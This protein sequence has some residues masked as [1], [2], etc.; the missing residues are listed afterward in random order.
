MLGNFG[1][2]YSGLK[3]IKEQPPGDEFSVAYVPEILKGQTCSKSTDWYCFG[4]F[5]HEMLTGKPPFWSRTRYFY[6]KFIFKFNREQTIKNI[7]AGV[8]KLPTDLSKEAKNLLFL[9]LN[10][11]PAKRLGASAKGACEIKSHPWFSSINWEDAK[12]MELPVPYL[13][14]KRAVKENQTWN[15][16]G[17]W[18]K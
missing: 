1:L 5:I 10:R 15:S 16:I 17:T 7:S 2:S 8:L 6:I 4:V 9:L 18:K 14:Y 12:N 11:N 3:E 13:P